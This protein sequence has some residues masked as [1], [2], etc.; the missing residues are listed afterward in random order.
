MEAGLEFHIDAAGN[1]SAI[2]KSNQKD[3]P[4]L[5]LGSHLD[6]VPNGGRYDGA[7]GV[8]AALEVIHSI[9][10][11]GIQ[12]PVNLEAVDFTD[13]EGTIVSFLGS[14]AFTGK[15]DLSLQIGIFEVVIKLLVY[16]LHERVWQWIPLGRKAVPMLEVE[17]EEER[18][19]RARN[20]LREL[21]YIE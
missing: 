4:T 3:A 12:L 19:D 18:I 5:L 9:S 15:L 1:H 16:Y 20:K 11:A 21:G 17:M 13:E 2:L 10:E 7:L 8:L 6:S 14:F